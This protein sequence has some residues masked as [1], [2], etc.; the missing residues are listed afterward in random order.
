MHEIQVIG[1]DGDI[2]LLLRV[3]M[4]DTNCHKMFLSK[5]LVYKRELLSLW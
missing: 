1:T 3:L 5:A 2:F 4:T